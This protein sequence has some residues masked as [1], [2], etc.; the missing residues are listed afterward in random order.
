MSK[1]FSR[2]HW[3][4]ELQQPEMGQEQSRQREVTGN[5][6][7]RWGH[8]AGVRWLVT[9]LVDGNL[10]ETQTGRR[11]GD[12]S[13]KVW[14][15]CKY[16][17]N[18]SIAFWFC[19]LRHF[20]SIC[21]H[22]YYVSCFWI[23]LFLIQPSSTFRLYLFYLPISSTNTHTNSIPYLCSIFLLTYQCQLCY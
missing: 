15:F 8:M 13:V 18:L 9:S 4:I 11:W 16:F 21:S 5:M 6:A 10:K 14:I 7:Q 3:E 20:Q 1:G 22:I 17:P 23:C 19:L 2:R 12:R